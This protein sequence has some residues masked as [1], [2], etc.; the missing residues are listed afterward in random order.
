MRKY[1]MTPEQVRVCN[2][3][4][5]RCGV[6]LVGSDYG[7]PDYLRLVANRKVPVRR[8]VAARLHGRPYCAACFKGMNDAAR[9]KANPN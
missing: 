3:A 7:D 4:G 8:R 6:E 9:A 1:V 2:C 5:E